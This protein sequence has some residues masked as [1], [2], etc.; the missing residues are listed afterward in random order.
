MFVESPVASHLENDFRNF[1]NII[2]TFFREIDHDIEKSE[3]A[4]RRT[5]PGQ[6]T[7]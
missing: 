6:Q 7:V 1:V 2:K 5:V 3:S 4:R